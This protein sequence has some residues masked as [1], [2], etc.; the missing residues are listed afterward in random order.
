MTG[1]AKRKGAVVFKKSA[2]VGANGKAKD[3]S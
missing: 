1:F 2:S 3:K